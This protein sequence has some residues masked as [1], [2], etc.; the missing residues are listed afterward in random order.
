LVRGLVRGEGSAHYGYHDYYGAGSYRMRQVVEGREVAGLATAHVVRL[1][2]A[3]L[4]GRA[5]A[6]EGVGVGP[7]LV[8]RSR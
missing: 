2:V 8:A 3:L 4:R 1:A 7:G 6:R 5:R